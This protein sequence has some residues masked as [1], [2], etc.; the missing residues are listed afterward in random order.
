MQLNLPFESLYII[1]A[2]QEAGFEAYLVGG[3]VRDLVLKQEGI[4]DFDFATNAKPE[5]IQNIFPESFYEN[6]FGTVSI[7]HE[8][9]L[10]QILNKD[11]S[12]P[13]QNLYK[14]LLDEEKKIFEK[15]QKGKIIN[16]KEAKKIHHSLKNKALASKKILDKKIFRTSLPPFEITTFRNDGDY[17]DHRRPDSVVW[18]KKISDDLNRRDFTI[19]AMAIEINNKYLN[20]IFKQNKNIQERYQLEANNWQLI[21]QYQGFKDLKNKLIRTVADPD[22]RFAEDAL[23]MLRAIRL[24][25][26]LNMKLEK[27]TYLSIQKNKDLLRF[28]SFE[29]IGAE[30]IK[31]LASDHPANGIKL[32]DETGLLN[33][34][35]PELKLGKKMDQPG[36]HTTDVWVHSL[37]ALEACPSSDP[38]VRLATLLHDVGKPETYVEKDKEITFYNHEVLGSR[39]ASK[40]AKRLRLSKKDVQRIFILVRYHMFYYQPKH[41]DASVR[42]FIKKVGL[43]NIDNILDLREGDRLGSG[44]KK[45]SWRLEEFKE[46][47]IE[48]LNQPMDL[49]DLEINGQTLIKELKLKP[50]PIIGQILNELLEKVLQNPEINKKGTLI[51]E[52]KKILKKGKK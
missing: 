39:I 17:A 6:Q 3:A 4:K 35:I 1:Y 28:V 25:V 10:N 24:A 2:L 38:I 49:S 20:K 5:E 51:N 19:N 26:Q 33:Y 43:E 46:R 14:R 44:A 27:E 15:N 11:L 32:L 41:S 36:H 52:A 42:R 40:I 18:G 7:T 8:K 16:L 30:M 31:I 45:T 21:D 22:Q 50:S 37:D 9:L 23:R 13:K 29:R 34:I 12:L 48:Q 47:I